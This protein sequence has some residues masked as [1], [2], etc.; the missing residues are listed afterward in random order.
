MFVWCAERR[1]SF[2]PLT[3]WSQCCREKCCE[4]SEWSAIYTRGP[5]HPHSRC[6]SE[7]KSVQ[8]NKTERHTCALNVFL[9]FSWWATHAAHHPHSEPLFLL[10]IVVNFGKTYK[11]IFYQSLFFLFLMWISTHINPTFVIFN[12]WTG[13][14]LDPGNTHVHSPDVIFW[15]IFILKEI[16]SCFSNGIYINGYLLVTCCESLVYCVW[17]CKCLYRWMKY[18]FTVAKEQILL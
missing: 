8:Q 17:W 15:V 11:N 9:M 16:F 12:C 6:K 13:F 2:F 3:C 18:W 10:C 14:C 4:S 7:N 1:L 5:A